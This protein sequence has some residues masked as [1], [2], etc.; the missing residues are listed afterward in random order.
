MKILTITFEREDMTSAEI[1][2]VLD[3]VALQQYALTAG[4]VRDGDVVV[5]RW[6]TTN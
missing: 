3:T 6:D 4:E 2:A 1:K 5:A